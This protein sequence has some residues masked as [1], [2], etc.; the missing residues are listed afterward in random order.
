VEVQRLAF[1]TS[2][3]DGGEWSASRLGRFTPRER[4]PDTRWIGGW[5]GPRRS[6]EEKNSHPPPG[7]EPRSSSGYL[8]V[9]KRNCRHRNKEVNV[10]ND[11]MQTFSKCVV[12]IPV[13]YACTTF[14]T[15]N[16]LIYVLA[17]LLTYLL[18]H[19]LTHSMVQDIV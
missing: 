3:L 16:L 10:Y 18:T 8:F 12:M 4:A 13:F 5:V 19:S 7:I 17:C 2:A 11:G 6:V 14:F 15:V 1:L 9:T